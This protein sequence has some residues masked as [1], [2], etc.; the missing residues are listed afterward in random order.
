MTVDGKTAKAVAIDLPI[1][2][3]FGKYI[4]GVAAGFI[5]TKV[6]EGAYEG[7]LASRRQKVAD[8]SR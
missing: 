7:W 6:V 2:H 4:I 5:A 3:Q 1:R 8:A